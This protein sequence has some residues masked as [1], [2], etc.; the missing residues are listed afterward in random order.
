MSTRVID[1]RPIPGDPLQYNGPFKLPAQLPYCRNRNVG[2]PIDIPADPGSFD[3]HV[4]S[5]LHGMLNSKNEPQGALATGEF[6]QP[7]TDEE[8]TEVDDWFIP[9]NGQEDNLAGL[10]GNF[11]YVKWNAMVVAAWTK[12][13]QLGPKME[14]LV[15]VYHPI[16]LYREL[17]DDGRATRVEIMG[18][19]EYGRVYGK[20]DVGDDIWALAR[21]RKKTVPEWR[22]KN[23][24]PTGTVKV[25]QS[26]EAVYKDGDFLPMDEYGRWV[27]P[28]DRPVRDYTSLIREDEDPG[29]RAILLAAA[30][31]L[32][33]DSSDSETGDE[34]E[35]ES[36][37]EVEIHPPEGAP[38][39][40]P[41]D[42]AADTPPPPEIVG[43]A[44]GKKVLRKKVAK[45][46]VDDAYRPDDG[47]EDDDEEEVEAPK[48]KRPARRRG[49]R[50]LRADTGT[51]ETLEET[52]VEKDKDT[53]EEIAVEEEEETEKEKE[54]GAEPDQEP[55]VDGPDP[56]FNY[57]PWETD[58]RLKDYEQRYEATQGRI[59]FDRRK[60]P[61]LK[62]YLLY[63][64][65]HV[66]PV[67]YNVNG[68]LRWWLVF[69]D[70]QVQVRGR[71]VNPGRALY[72]FNPCL[73][74]R[75]AGK[76]DDVNERAFIEKIPTYLKALFTA[77]LGALD[78]HITP[79]EF[80]SSESHDLLK[81]LE[82]LELPAHHYDHPGKFRF[83]ASPRLGGWRY[84]HNLR[85]PQ[86]GVEIIYAMDMLLRL[87]EEEDALHGAVWRRLAEDWLPDEIY[88][89]LNYPHPV[90]HPT[91]FIARDLA[92]HRMWDQ[93]YSG[94]QGSTLNTIRTETLTEVQ[95]YFGKEKV[96]GFPFRDDIGENPG[97]PEKAYQILEDLFFGH[98]DV[99]KQLEGCFENGAQAVV[100]GIR[101]LKSKDKKAK[102]LRCT[103]KDGCTNCHT[104]HQAM[105]AGSRI[106]LHGRKLRHPFDD[107]KTEW[108]GTAEATDRLN[109]IDEFWQKKSNMGAGY[110]RYR[111]L[112]EDFEADGTI[113]N[114]G[115][116]SDPTS[117]VETSYP[118]SMI[119]LVIEKNGN[120]VIHAGNRPHNNWRVNG[121][122]VTQSEVI[123]MF[124]HVS[125]LH[126]NDMHWLWLR[127]FKT[128]DKGEEF[129]RFVKHDGVIARK[130]RKDDDSGGYY[131]DDNDED[132][133]D[134]DSERRKRIP[135]SYPSHTWRDEKFRSNTYDMG[136]A[137]PHFH[138]H[139]RTDEE[140]RSCEKHMWDSV[141]GDI[142]LCQNP[143]CMRWTTAG[144]GPGNAYFKFLIPCF[145]SD[146]VRDRPE[147]K[148]A[149]SLTCEDWEN[150][151]CIPNDL[152]V[153]SNHTPGVPG[154]IYVANGVTVFHPEMLI[155]SN[156]G[157]ITSSGLQD[158]SKTSRTEGD[159]T[160]LPL[161]PLSFHRIAFSPIG[162][163]EDFDH[164]QVWLRENF[165]YEPILLG[166]AH[167]G[168]LIYDMTMY[169]RLNYYRTLAWNS[170]DPGEQ[171]HYWDKHKINETRLDRYYIPGW[172][173]ASF[174]LQYQLPQDDPA[175]CGED[176][177]V[178]TDLDGNKKVTVAGAGD[179]FAWD[180][181]RGTIGTGAGDA[182][183]D[184]SGVIRNMSDAERRKHFKR[185]DMAQ[186]LGLSKGKKG[187]DE[188]NL[189]AKMRKLIRVAPGDSA[190]KSTRSEITIRPRVAPRMIP[191]EEPT[192]ETSVFR[193]RPYDVPTYD[194]R[195]IPTY[196]RFKEGLSE[197]EEKDVEAIFKQLI[198]MA[199]GTTVPSRQ[200]N[201]CRREITALN[202]SLNNAQRLWV[203]AMD[204]L[205]T[206]TMNFTL[207]LEF[208]K[209]DSPDEPEVAPNWTTPRYL[210]IPDDDYHGV[211]NV[212]NPGLKALPPFPPP[213]KDLESGKRWLQV[214]YIEN[215]D[216]Y[217][218]NPN[219]KSLWHKVMIWRSA[220]LPTFT[221]AQLAWHVE[222]EKLILKA[223]PEKFGMPD[224]PYGG[225][226]ASRSS[227]GSH[228]SSHSTPPI[229][230][231]AAWGGRFWG[232]KK[233]PAKADQVSEESG[234]LDP[235][236][237]DQTTTQ[238]TKDPKTAKEEAKPRKQNTK[239]TSKKL[240]KRKATGLEGI[241][242][243]RIKADKPVK[244]IAHVGSKRQ[245]VDLPPGTF[246]IPGNDAVINPEDRLLP[247]T[248]LTYVANGVIQEECIRVE[249]PDE[250]PFNIT[251]RQTFI[252][253]GES[254]DDQEELEE[255][256]GSSQDSS[257]PEVESE[258]IHEEQELEPELG[259]DDEVQGKPRQ[260]SKDKAPKEAL[261][262]RPSGITYVG[263]VPASAAAPPTSVSKKV[264]KPLHKTGGAVEKEP[265]KGGG[266]DKIESHQ[267]VTPKRVPKH[268]DTQPV[269]PDELLATMA[270]PQSTPKSITHKRPIDQVEQPTQ[271]LT[272][273]KRGRPKKIKP[274]EELP[275]G[276]DAE[277]GVTTENQAVEAPAVGEKKAKGKRGRKPKAVKEAEEL[278]AKMKEE[279]DKRRELEDSQ[280]R[281]AN[282]E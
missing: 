228:G 214:L 54:P 93:T 111:Y 46:T 136:D 117:I 158:H 44:G 213:S 35:W 269:T 217:L 130:V 248:F 194:R 108:W 242:E 243:E 183:P 179:P 225:V 273:G 103:H 152:S 37:R 187:T 140:Y 114:R 220:I 223:K 172:L 229:E 159:V 268:K 202:S 215:G 264:T 219:S 70:M 31:A 246:A 263:T 109:A 10:G 12:Q 40:I 98:R 51:G 73:H 116:P 21:S 176:P 234:G 197:K 67:A 74:S 29:L 80:P 77:E 257:E 262:G 61:R 200:V 39:V 249:K 3:P 17:G 38:I 266:A 157:H 66:I 9:I 32:N 97:L 265:K 4:A 267:P 184:P 201:I 254:S 216:K 274:V 131:Q 59:N 134:S 25:V 275:E 221:P 92:A 175:V 163:F 185:Y 63:K 126:A 235:M 198:N 90:R 102:D 135:S 212:Q 204:D 6:M 69:I 137:T 26:L 209:A 193:T 104:V 89:R 16:E 173:D 55:S 166:E 7:I 42:G 270:A 232:K 68:E 190:S 182:L 71:G 278:L 188:P 211:P 207:P 121:V 258:E 36:D 118:Q 33:E 27:P 115:G 18:E 119:S 224:V 281:S 255:V 101:S 48:R 181:F 279:E 247:Q 162:R 82:R 261:T 230:V 277:K 142:F 50:G 280:R 76:D 244:R 205:I 56:L 95:R 150:N 88:G 245:K 139:H 124:S 276:E 52:G 30:R 1:P 127:R 271:P 14:K 239:P 143:A 237:I 106:I 170:L 240:L 167:D 206:E 145:N 133:D 110:E 178:R 250:D 226:L 105:T 57:F 168:G 34:Y 64:R 177:T 238:E 203:M 72:I 47:D 259:V 24:A 87:F 144:E 256:P 28:A 120:A 23:P 5:A 13:M 272:T 123:T 186:Y 191:T 180:M 138:H 151:R 53:D 99:W 260:K 122:R 148:Y 22:R 164:A 153:I 253:N 20:L 84:T 231:R 81:R 156:E 195:V 251:I 83:F 79:V 94:T 174:R 241:Q 107:P 196:P 189:Q 11:D 282:Q 210:E 113:S 192:P 227:E 19:V 222:F 233:N 252:P 165:N 208:P 100:V 218:E 236:V 2:F 62:K 129:E 171:R 8:K 146:C 199:K 154:H 155:S 41:L 147:G 60:R 141:I 125:Y 128:G 43:G 15:K 49:L 75:A 161:P 78:H 112:R 132:D 96:K 91:P 58:E 45:K 160:T 65:W 169:E 149:P 85:N 86:S